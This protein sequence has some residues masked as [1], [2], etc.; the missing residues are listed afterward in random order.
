MAW[1]GWSTLQKRAERRL[2]VLS[3]LNRQRPMIFMND[4]VGQGPL[5]F[6]KRNTMAWRPTRTENQSYNHYFSK[7]SVPATLWTRWLKIFIWCTV[8]YNRA[9]AKISRCDIFQDACRVLLPNTAEVHRCEH[10]TKTSKDQ[11]NLSDEGDIMFDGE[12]NVLSLEMLIWNLTNLK[13]AGPTGA[14]PRSRRPVYMLV[15][16]DAI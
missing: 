10:K 1:L 11:E 14:I 3:E 4:H 5:C 7:T 9:F 12:P 13:V 8:W 15:T 2:R 16:K 6:E